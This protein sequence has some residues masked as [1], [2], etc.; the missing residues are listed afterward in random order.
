SLQKPGARRA[1]LLGME[2]DA[3][4]AAR[5]GLGDDALGA[6][7][8]ARRLG[9]VGV[10][11]GEALAARPDRRP[12]APRGPALAAAG[13]TAMPGAGLV[14]PGDLHGR[15]FGEG[16][17]SPCLRPAARSARPTALNAASAT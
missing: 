15:P 6:R 9:R 13:G 2:L 5:P 1:A 10:G 8:R 11:E 16:R 7:R 3:V 4:E 12:G 14:A 17:P